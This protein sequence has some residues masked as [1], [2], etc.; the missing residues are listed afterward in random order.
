MSYR[1]GNKRISYSPS[2]NFFLSAEYL[3]LSSI[4]TLNCFIH[5]RDKQLVK[6][7][8]MSLVAYENSYRIAWDV[9]DLR[10]RF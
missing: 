1:D 4:V 6:V 10:V 7:T 2:R 5:A 3:V 9:I 8:V